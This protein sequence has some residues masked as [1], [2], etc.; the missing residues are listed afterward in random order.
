MRLQEL[1]WSWGKKKESPKKLTFPQVFEAF[2]KKVALDSQPPRETLACRHSLFFH[3]QVSAIPWCSVLLIFFFTGHLQVSAIFAGH[4]VVLCRRLP[5]SGM[6]DFFFLSFSSPA[7]L[8]LCFASPPAASLFFF[9]GFLS[10]F[11]LF[12]DLGCRA[13]PTRAPLLCLLCLSY[14]Q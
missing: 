12:F 8:L 7:R 9:A 10:L 1:N 11:L 3:L 2:G 4:P 6:A 13:T 14:F 5:V